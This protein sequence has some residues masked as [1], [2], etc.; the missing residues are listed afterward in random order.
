ML[1]PEVLPESFAG[2]EFTLSLI[3]ISRNTQAGVLAFMEA[4]GISGFEANEQFFI[5]DGKV[6]YAYTCLLYTSRCV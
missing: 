1:Y 2:M 4:F 6:K 5:E 3:H